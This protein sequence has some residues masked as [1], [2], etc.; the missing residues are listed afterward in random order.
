M[1]GAATGKARLPKFSLVLGIDICCEVDDLSCLG[2]LEK[3]KETSQIRCH[4]TYPSTDGAMLHNISLITF[5]RWRTQHLTPQT[6]PFY[7]SVLKLIE[8]MYVNVTS[9]NNSGTAELHMM[10]LIVII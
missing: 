6:A 9:L 5:H 3:C 4:S 7:I 2:M 1:M 10:L 8:T